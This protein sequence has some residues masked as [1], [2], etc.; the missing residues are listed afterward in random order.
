MDKVIRQAP[1]DTEKMDRAKAEREKNN[2]PEP[3]KGF[4]KKKK[5]G[6]K[7]EQPAAD[8]FGEHLKNIPCDA[9]TALGLD[10][11]WQYDRLVDYLLLNGPLVPWSVSTSK[12]L[13]LHRM[14]TNLHRMVIKIHRRVYV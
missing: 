14:S 6:E 4:D 5:R 2:M 7:G 1:Q 3:P 9:A 10:N 8:K 12:V 11:K 13:Y